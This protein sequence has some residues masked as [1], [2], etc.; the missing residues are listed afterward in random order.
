MKE[1]YDKELAPEVREKM[2]KNLV[3]IGI[4]SVVMLFAGFTSAYIVSMGSA[5]WLKYS[6]PTPFWISTCLIGASSLLYI[7]AIRQIKKGNVK[8]LKIF[9]ILTFLCGL[10]FVYFQFKGY[11]A[12]TE[13]GVHPVNNHIMVTDGRYGDYYEVKMNGQFIEVDGNTYKI[14]GKEM[15]TD[16]QNELVVFAKQFVQNDVK[17]PFK[18]SQYGKKFILY[19]NNSPLMLLNGELKK[20][21]GASLEYTDR[22]RLRDLSLH[23]KDGRG[24]FFIKG[25]M[26]KDFNVYF[27]GQTLEYKNRELYW[28]GKVLSRYLQLKATET[29]DTASSFLYIIT[30]LHLL[31]I[32]AALIYLLRMTIFSFSGRFSET[33]HLS[34]RLGAIFWHFLGLLWLYLL[35]FLLF[36]H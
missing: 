22:M 26:G 12:L 24:D 6:L 10:F 25:E 15:S 32:V 34:L 17:K 19:L 9:M 33:N 28:K 21:N 35:L 18:I 16:Q 5:F 29:A 23:L 1:E 7:L 4:F 14:A 27:Q 36:I 31:H 11:G 13:K 30:I 3:Y 8:N 2:K 20:K